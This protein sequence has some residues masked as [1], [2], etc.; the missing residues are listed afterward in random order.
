MDNVSASGIKAL[1]FDVFGTVVDWR[2]GVAREVAAFI[3][4][5][6]V[7]VDPFEFADAWRREYAPAMAEVRA[8]N[9]GFV[10]LD[11]LHRENLEKALM[12]FGIDPQSIPA[13]SLDE[14]N[15]AWH[16][17]DPWPDA[18]PGL[19]R[20]KERFIIAPL[21][22]G[23]IRLMLDIAKRAGIPWDAILGAEVVRMYKPAPSVYLDTAELLAIEPAEL[24]MVAAHNDDLK[25]AKACGLKT[26]FVSRPREHGGAQTKDLFAEGQWDF[27]ASSFIE[28]A[29]M[30]LGVGQSKRQ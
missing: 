11:V 24:C 17:L 12:G 26:A 18:V 25:A 2:S 14:L 21:S 28:L 4:S 5:A 19:S 3:A 8:G 10:R 15:L 27:V 22:N 1:V 7:T 16:K 13:A 9:R 30:M 23:N 6:Q 20:L 29:D